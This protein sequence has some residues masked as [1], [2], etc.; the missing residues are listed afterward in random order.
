MPAGRPNV[1]DSHDSKLLI[2]QELLK[3]TSHAKISAKFG[4]SIDALAR[5]QKR[6]LQRYRAN[7]CSPIP[8]E[9]ALVRAEGDKAVRDV[10]MEDIA[11]FRGISSDV[12][13][14]MMAGMPANR[15]LD[16]DPKGLASVLREARGVT[17][18][19]ARLD[20][21]LQDRS[22]TQVNVV[23]LSAAP[24]HQAPYQAQIDNPPVDDVLDAEWCEIS[25]GA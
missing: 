16:C 14:A 11:R 2:I 22:A 5:Y 6:E 9:S 13:T 3:R 25:P 12:L 8:G 4:I 20:G 10:V 23:I 7:V 1:I 24:E 21:R 18:L 17:E 19:H 15:Q